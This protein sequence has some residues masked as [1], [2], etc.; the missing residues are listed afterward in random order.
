[1]CIPELSE[2]RNNLCNEQCLTG[3]ARGC[4][5]GEPRHLPKPG[6]AGEV[7][8]FDMKTVRPHVGD[9][10]IMLLAVDFCTNKCFAWDL[11]DGSGDP[12]HVQDIL[13]HFFAEHELP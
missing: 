7:I 8:G 10:W 3:K 12:K 11:D 4:A 2:K 6:S 13:L 9:R 1:M 5:K